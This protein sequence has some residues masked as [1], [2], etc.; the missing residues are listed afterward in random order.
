MTLDPRIGVYFSIG[1]AIISV[2]LLC[3]AEFTT[4][5]G[6]VSTEKLLAALAIVNAVVNAINGVLHMIPSKPNATNEFPLG[7]K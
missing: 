6:T 1:A 7:P 5:F 2:L 4:L 3:G